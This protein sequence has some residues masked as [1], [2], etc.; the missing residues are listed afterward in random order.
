M[1]VNTLDPFFVL[2]TNIDSYERSLVH[3]YFSQSSEVSLGLHDQAVFCPIRAWGSSYAQSYSAALRWIIVNAE[4]QT[5]RLRN[6]SQLRL[7][8]YRAEAYKALDTALKND[9][10]DH[11]MT[12]IILAVMGD[13]EKAIVHLK[14]L[15]NVIAAKGGFDFFCN[16]FDLVQPEH[17]IMMYSFCPARSV[18]TIA[19]LTRML[20][21]FLLILQEMYKRA[22]ELKHASL[23]SGQA[24]QQE[25][26]M[27]HAHQD[28]IT[29][30]CVGGLL[31]KAYNPD[32]S[33]VR[34]A[35]QFVMHY[36]LQRTLLDMSDKPLCVQARFLKALV[37]VSEASSA[38]DVDG[39]WLLKPGAMVSMICRARQIV[40]ND[41]STEPSY[42]SIRISAS[43]IEALK[44]FG[45]LEEPGWELIIGKLQSWITGDDLELNAE[46]IEGL[47]TAVYENWFELPR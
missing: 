37:F 38:R 16:H 4:E 13:D 5:C 7:A 28:L 29:S 32:L 2:P 1:H 36:H 34:K 22:R 35:R 40:L 31:R 18:K 47:R 46:E 30:V 42:E 24:S 27:L 20:D 21:R 15:D 3:W 41:Y 17:F 11:A 43:T 26:V 8:T 12:G 6:D 45:Y 44:I 9:T 14:G 19:D 10:I 23:T 39:S 33:Y 25:Q